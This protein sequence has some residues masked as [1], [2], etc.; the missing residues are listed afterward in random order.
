MDYP[1]HRQSL[2]GDS[3]NW[4]AIS[5]AADVLAAIGVIASLL[6][7]AG[8]IRAQVKEAELSGTRDLARDWHHLVLS[9]AENQES[10]DV[11]ERA[12]SNYADL[13][14]GD[15][16]KAF[17]LFSSAMRILELQYFHLDQARLDS[18][19]FSGI[20]H[21]MQELGTFP[22]IR[23][24]WESNKQEYDAAF[25]EFAE[26]VSPIGSGATESSR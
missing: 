2:G 12:I 18:R 21:R 25:I 10:F 15:R 9:I 20:Q 22:G 16:I 7:L 24:W 6:Y 5:A 17:M 13:P 4:T 26:R 14:R 8:Q 3:M 11:Y 1:C 19:Y 23:Q